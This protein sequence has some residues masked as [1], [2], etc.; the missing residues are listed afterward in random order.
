MAKVI[1]LFLM[2]YDAKNEYRFKGFHGT[3][4]A[5]ASKIKQQH[6]ETSGKEKG[7]WLGQGV[8]FFVEGGQ[9]GVGIHPLNDAFKFCRN[10]KRINSASIVVLSCIIAVEKKYYL[11]LTHPD[12]RKAFI[13]FCDALN[14][15]DGMT[16]ELEKYR[17]KYHLKFFNIESFIFDVAGN[18]FLGSPFLEKDVVMADLP[19][20]LYD[21]PPKS[22]K[23]AVRIGNTTQLRVRNPKQYIHR[24]TI[25][26]EDIDYV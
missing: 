20:K 7:N 24:T 25:K 4:F 3:E 18:K 1:I 16:E 12:N 19:Q 13:Q 17:K 2:E 10:E 6:F 5:N 14:R 11:D 9:Y 23:I 15:L 8:Y 26:E 22:N 21:S